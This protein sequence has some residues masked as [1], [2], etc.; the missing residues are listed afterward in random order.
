M[1]QNNQQA[2]QQG[3]NAQQM[4]QMMQMWMLWRNQQM[5]MQRQMQMQNQGPAFWQQWANAGVPGVG[6]AQNMIAGANASIQSGLNRLNNSVF[7]DPNNPPASKLDKVLALL[8]KVLGGD[9]GLG[10]LGEIAGAKGAVSKSGNIGHGSK[11]SVVHTKENIRKPELAVRSITG[12]RGAKNARKIAGNNQFGKQLQGAV[13]AL[14][15]G[16]QNV[17]APKMRKQAFDLDNQAKQLQHQQMVGNI[18]QQVQRQGLVSD[19]TKR[20]REA[21]RGYADLLG[22]ITKM[23]G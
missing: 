18:N 16:F 5:Q 20:A 17:E 8:S 1:A 14:D 2:N 6:I 23:L 22:S 11:G 7:F 4:Q 15:Q 10:A 12:L 21:R 13:G 9:G 3:L 19:A